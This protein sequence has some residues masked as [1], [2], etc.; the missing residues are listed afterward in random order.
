MKEYNLKEEEIN[1]FLKEFNN[2]SSDSKNHYSHKIQTIFLRS[3]R[4]KNS[5]DKYNKKSDK[6]DLDGDYMVINNIYEELYK[7]DNIKKLRIKK[8]NI[9]I[10]QK[11]T[12]RKI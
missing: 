7:K 5:N 1:E 3:I 11:W 8:I 4:T 12:L 9:K 6:I 2:F 10:L